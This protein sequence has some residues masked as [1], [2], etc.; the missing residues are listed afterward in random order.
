LL[1]KVASILADRP[2]EGR[3]M[4]DHASRLALYTTDKRP[5]E[6]GRGR[7]ECARVPAPRCRREG[8]HEFRWASGALDTPAWR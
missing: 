8:F 5:N 6:S 7:H 4:I 1:D 2:K 3:L